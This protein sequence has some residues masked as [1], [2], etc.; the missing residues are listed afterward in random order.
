MCGVILILTP[1]SL[2]FKRLG[3][4]KMDRKKIEL[5]RINAYT[6]PRSSSKTYKVVNVCRSST[7]ERSHKS[8]TT[9]FTMRI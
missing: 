4:K 9:Y 2:V 6:R 3:Q 8:S 1:F 5:T 7:V